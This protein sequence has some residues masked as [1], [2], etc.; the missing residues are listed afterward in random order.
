MTWEKW[1]AWNGEAFEQAHGNA[2]TLDAVKGAYEDGFKAGSG[3]MTRTYGG[4]S[5][6]AEGRTQSWKKWIAMEGDA[7]ERAHRSASTLDAVKG[8]AFEQHRAKQRALQRTEDVRGKWRNGGT[9]QGHVLQAHG[10]FSQKAVDYYNAMAPIALKGV[11][12]GS[13]KVVWNGHTTTKSHAQFDAMHYSVEDT[14][15]GWLLEKVDHNAKKD[16]S[17]TGLTMTAG[18]NVVSRGDDFTSGGDGV[19]ARGALRQ[20]IIDANSMSSQAITNADLKKSGLK[21]NAKKEMYARLAGV[22]RRLRG[23]SGVSHAAQ[24]QAE[25]MEGLS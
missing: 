16:V 17:V 9:Y 7:F 24:R 21:W 15:V 23:C 8:P 2:S 11:N 6:P 20:G 22:R 18:S 19:S 25:P 1:I 4:G 14:G 10:T 12:V 13:I 3:D 5:S